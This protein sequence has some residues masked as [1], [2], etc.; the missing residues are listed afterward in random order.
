MVNEGTIETVIETLI[1]YYGLKD[2]RNVEIVV[3]D[4]EESDK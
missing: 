1:G 2:W 3:V 4:D